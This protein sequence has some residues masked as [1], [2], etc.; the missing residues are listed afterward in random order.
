MKKIIINGANGFIA[1]NFIHEMRNKNYEVVALVRASSKYSSEQRMEN[2]LSEI[3][4]GEHV[5]FNK[6]KTYSYSLLDDDFSITEK[7]MEN[8]FDGDVDFFHFAASLKFDKKTKDEIFSINVNGVRNAIEVFLKYATKKSRFFFVGTA[9]SCGKFEGLFKEKFYPNKDITQFRNYYEQ[10]K[11]FA[12]NV[13]KENIDKN[14]LNGHVIRLSQ[15]V[16][17]SITGVT[18]TDYGIFDFAKRIHSLAARYPNKTVRVHIDPYSTQNLIPINTVVSYLMRTLEVNELPVI[19]NFIAKN[20][21]KNIQLI[22]GVCKLLPINIT[23]VGHIEVGEM[24]ALER[25]IHA[26]MSFSGNY[27]DT[28]ILFDTKNLNSII[29]SPGDEVN[30][31]NIFKMMKYFFDNISSN[32]GKQI[33]AQA[34]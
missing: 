1:S 7:Q 32:G 24:D 29:L 15:V 23:L 13:V 2:A 34:V 33:L 28:N 12:E 21:M 25:I 27:I 9:Y 22:N 31:K 14:R 5:N 8:I 3:N 10:S 20:S 11:R 17:N 19:M 18:K 4:D 30:E 16:G 26:G 6:L